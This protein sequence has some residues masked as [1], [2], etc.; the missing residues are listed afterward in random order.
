MFHSDAN[1]SRQ[2][3]AGAGAKLAVMNKFNACSS[4]HAPDIGQ[5][6]TPNQPYAKRTVGN[7]NIK[8]MLTKD[9]VPVLPDCGSAFSNSRVAC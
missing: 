7:A 9:D 1:A 5:A 2:T 8:A 6:T 4:R 3:S